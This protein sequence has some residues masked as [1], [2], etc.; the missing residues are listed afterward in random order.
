M[1]R[2]FASS[3][4]FVR[5]RLRSPR[6]TLRERAALRRVGVHEEG[7]GRRYYYWQCYSCS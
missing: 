3:L 4:P 2:S 5:E 1:A 7:D 6:V